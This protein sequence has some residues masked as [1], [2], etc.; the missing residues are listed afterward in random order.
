MEIKYNTPTGEINAATQALFN[1]NISEV[2]WNSIN[3]QVRKGYGYTYDDIY[4]ITS[5]KYAEKNG[6]DWNQN[7]G[8]YNLNTIDYDANGN[9]LSLSRNG[10]AFGDVYSLMDDLDYVYSGNQLQSVT[11][12]VMLSHT[13]TNQFKA[14]SGSGAQYDYDANG[15][16]TIDPN[17]KIEDITYNEQNLPT[18]IQFS[19][20][21]SITYIYDAMGT[22][23]HKIASDH[24]TETNSWFLSGFQYNDDGLEFFANEEGRVVRAMLFGNTINPGEKFRF[25]Y[26][27]KDHLGNLRLT[28]SDMDFDNSIDASSEVLQEVNY[29]PFGLE[30]SYTLGDLPPLTSPENQYKYNGKEKQTEFDLNWLDYGARFYDPTLGRWNV[31]DNKSES[32]Y[33]WTPYRYA[34]NNPLKF[35]DPD[36]QLEDWYVD[37]NDQIVYDE[38]IN[39]QEDLVAAGIEGDYIAESFVGNDQN[40]DLFVFDSDGEVSKSDATVS[41]V[42]AGGLDTDGLIEIESTLISEANEN[43]IEEIS[44]AVLI[45]LVADNLFGVGV[46]DDPAIP[47]VKGI[48]I[49][50]NLFETAAV[51]EFAAEHTSNKRKSNWNIHSKTRSGEQRGQARNA[52]RGNKNKKYKKKDNP[53]K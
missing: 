50:G 40:G 6:Y 3:S 43:P 34:F 35:I 25:E 18:Y 4:R 24:G 49:I 23:H 22:K 31:I 5:G 38:N 15:N 36:G 17:K 32:A 27:Y 9:I 16:M 7:I 37:E 26:S 28:F 33:S 1:G 14:L 21:R 29:Y 12:N 48:G 45:V 10:L 20:S 19:N 30:H 47:I 46:V 53:N 13:H 2:H 44:N 51:Y 41:G 39:S 11:E 8:N 52:K 42:E